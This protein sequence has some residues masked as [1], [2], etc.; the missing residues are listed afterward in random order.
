[1]HL[2]PLL[3]T[4]PAQVLAVF[5]LLPGAFMLSVGVGDPYV[6]RVEVLAQC[7]T[8]FGLVAALRT[9]NELLPT[10]TPSP[11]ALYTTENAIARICGFLSGLHSQKSDEKAASEAGLLEISAVHDA[12]EQ[13]MTG[14]GFLWYVFAQGREAGL[15]RCAFA[16]HAPPRACPPGPPL[17]T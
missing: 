10:P 9:A 4:F 3:L 11:K 14:E 1:M 12:I 17:P 13:A 6:F 16:P 5:P 7:S 2:P 8:L 15:V